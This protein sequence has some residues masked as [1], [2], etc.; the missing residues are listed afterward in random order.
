MI[1]HQVQKGSA[2]AAV[3]SKLTKYKSRMKVDGEME[4]LA[5]AALVAKGELQP[6]AASPNSGDNTWGAQFTSIKASGDD[7]DTIKEG[8]DDEEDEDELE[9]MILTG[10]SVT[11][12][13]TCALYGGGCGC[14]RRR[15][16]RA[17]GHDHGR[18][19]YQQQ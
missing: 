15:G 7:G 4:W 14:R 11:G 17:S 3:R 10:R 18:R 13:A 1:K 6:P 19:W 8:E 5:V 12:A 9:R 2:V 16:S